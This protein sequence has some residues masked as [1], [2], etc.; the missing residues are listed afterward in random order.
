[1]FPW[2]SLISKPQS[3]CQE[4]NQRSSSVLH[5]YFDP[6]SR[7]QPPLPPLELFLRWRSFSG[8]PK[9]LRIILKHNFQC[10]FLF[11][12]FDDYLYLTLYP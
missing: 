10:K 2:T 12:P 5:P 11:F 9:I 3:L 1:M 8:N 7:F 4:D 6:N